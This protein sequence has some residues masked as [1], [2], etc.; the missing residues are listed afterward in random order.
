MLLNLLLVGLTTAI[1]LPSPAN[2]APASNSAA[3]EAINLTPIVVPS[4]STSIPSNDDDLS[5]DRIPWP[6][7]GLPGPV[8]PETFAPPPPPHKSTGGKYRPPINIDRYRD[9]TAA[10]NRPLGWTTISRP[11]LVSKLEKI[12]EVD[13]SALANRRLGRRL[14]FAKRGSN[15]KEKGQV[16]EFGMD[17][18]NQVHKYGPE[19]WVL[20]RPWERVQEASVEAKREGARLAGLQEGIVILPHPIVEEKEVDCEK[21]GACDVDEDEDEDEDEEYEGD[22]H[23]GLTMEQWEKIFLTV[24]DPDEKEALRVMYPE[25]WQAFVREQLRINIKEGPEGKDE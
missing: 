17:P 9:E 6:V 3:G 22:E 14:R 13:E 21:F 16:N 25:Y 12:D 4:T 2:S 24:A 10:F 18:A 19:Y 15:E 7:V 5:A 23:P 8:R 11:S 20:T 1:P